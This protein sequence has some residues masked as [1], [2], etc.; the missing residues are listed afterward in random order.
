MADETTRVDAFLYETLTADAPLSGGWFA[1]QAPRGTATPFG[2][3]GL[4]SAL[5]VQT[6]SADRIMVNAIYSVRV[7]TEAETFSEIQGD[8]DA[9]DAALH[10]SDGTA[11]GASVMSATREEIIRRVEV[12]EGRELRSYGGYYR[13]LVQLP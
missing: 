1:E 13:I 7:V 8:V 12:D 5:D 11:G 2:V 3:F 10:Q 6:A 9:V 4:I